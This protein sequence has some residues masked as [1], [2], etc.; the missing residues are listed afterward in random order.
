MA[1]QQARPDHVRAI[2]ALGTLALSGLLALSLTAVLQG[3]A[4]ATRTEGAPTRDVLPARVDAHWAQ[5][6]WQCSAMPSLLKQA[7]CRTQLTE[8]LVPTH[9][10]LPASLDAVQSQPELRRVG[11]ARID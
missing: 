2:Q 10:A 6:H 3:A 4:Q 5:V 1:A 9:A 11:E 8:L 7:A